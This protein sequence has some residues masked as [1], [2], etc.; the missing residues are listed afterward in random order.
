MSSHDPA[1][2]EEKVHEFLEVFIMHTINHKSNRGDYSGLKEMELNFLRSNGHQ[3]MQKGT[4]DV[5]QKIR[6]Q[7]ASRW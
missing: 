3:L 4:E 1:A 2:E 5:L 7:Q 6:F